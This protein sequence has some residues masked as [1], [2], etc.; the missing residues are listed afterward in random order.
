MLVVMGPVLQFPVTDLFA[1]AII[2]GIIPRRHVC[3]LRA[4][5]VLAEPVARPDPARGRPA[6]TSD[7][8]W[9]EAILVIGSIVTFFP[10]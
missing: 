6:L 4:D 5:P 8:Y 7:H 3:R 2:P 9:L 10:H 1:A